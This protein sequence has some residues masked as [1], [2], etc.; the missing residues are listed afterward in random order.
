MR[1]ARSKGIR[2][3]MDC[4]MM[5]SCLMGLIRMIRIQMGTGTMTGMK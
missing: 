1:A 2:T 5:T 3:E 4:L